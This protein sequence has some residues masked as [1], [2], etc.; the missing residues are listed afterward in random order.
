MTFVEAITENAP[1][2]YVQDSRWFFRPSYSCFKI[3]LESLSEA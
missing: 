1:T 2:T 3:A